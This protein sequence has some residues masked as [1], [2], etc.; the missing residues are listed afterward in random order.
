MGAPYIIVPELLTRENYGSW[1]IWMRNYLLGKELWD[2][3]DG[4]FPKPDEATQQVG[5][6]TGGRKMG[7]RCM[8]Y[9]CHVD[10]EFFL[11]LV[12]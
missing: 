2:I 5:F 3:V 7:K 10:Q 9:K 6:M 8:P 12:R 4:T 11:L 1:K